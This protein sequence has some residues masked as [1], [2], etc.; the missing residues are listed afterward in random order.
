MTFICSSLSKS[1]IWYIQTLKTFAIP[2]AVLKLGIVYPL[3][4]KISSFNS[5]KLKIKLQINNA[6]IHTI[7]ILII[8]IPNRIGRIIQTMSIT[9]NMTKNLNLILA[10]YLSNFNIESNYH[11]LHFYLIIWLD[12]LRFVKVFLSLMASRIHLFHCQRNQAMPKIYANPL[13][14]S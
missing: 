11:L 5:D 14:R 7:P 4:A 10:E 1:K 12:K 9:T 3:V 2:L 13:L 6:S 8:C